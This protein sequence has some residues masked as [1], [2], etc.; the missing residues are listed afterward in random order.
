MQLE[1]T[2][3]A[4]ARELGSLWALHQSPAFERYV[5]EAY[6]IA[7]PAPPHFR[8]LYIGECEEGDFKLGPK[9][10]LIKR[11]WQVDDQGLK[12]VERPELDWDDN[13]PYYPTPEILFYVAGNEVSIV[14]T[15]GRRMRRWFRGELQFGDAG[16]RLTK[17]QPL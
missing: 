14:E 1:Q 4:I 16:I 6:D 13:I 17:L 8:C 3:T 15:L 7:P 2:T 9:G 5:V 10:G 11:W 12:E